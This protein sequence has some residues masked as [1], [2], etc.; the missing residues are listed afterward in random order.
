MCGLGPVLSLK[1]GP[2]GCWAM[3]H[4]GVILDQ[5]PIPGLKKLALLFLFLRAFLSG[6]LRYHIRNLN[7]LVV[8]K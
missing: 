8:K 7:L 4:S 2:R 1:S 5:L 6:A 3:E